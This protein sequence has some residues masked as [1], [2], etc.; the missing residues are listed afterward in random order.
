VTLEAY[1]QPTSASP[2][3]ELSDKGEYPPDPMT[4]F[5]NLAIA[6]GP[7]PVGAWQQDNFVNTF[8]EHTAISADG[9]SIQLYYR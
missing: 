8:G 6:A 5:A 9:R 7:N 2:P 1:D 4:N 3:Y